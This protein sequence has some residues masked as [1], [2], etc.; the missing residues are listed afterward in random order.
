M[1]IVMTLLI[2]VQGPVTIFGMAILIIML[3]IVKLIVGQMQNA[4]LVPI[5]ILNTH[6][7]G[8]WIS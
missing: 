1:A 8:I 7:F 5:V 2:I 6:F 3:P 4:R